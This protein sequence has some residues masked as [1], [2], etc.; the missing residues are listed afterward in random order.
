MIRGIALIVAAIV[1]GVVLLNAT[2][3]PAPFVPKVAASD[4]TTTS[5]TV[6]AGSS[7]TA[8]TT[9][10]TTAAKAHKPSEV[11]VLVVNGSRVSGAA[12]RIATS[13][14][15]AGY[16][17][18]PSGNTPNPAVASNVYYKPGYEADAR[19]IAGRLTPAPGVLPMPTPAPVKD[20]AGANV[21]VVVAADLAGR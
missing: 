19:A 10:T 16:L 4:G 6:A 9:A 21:L 17:L 15:A 14:G 11:T 8:S 18:K 5:T 12:G 7:T 3:S 2:D 13:L 20:L 1:L